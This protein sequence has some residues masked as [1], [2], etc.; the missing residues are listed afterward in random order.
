MEF[1]ERIRK[2]REALDMTQE[3]LAAA[4]GY[5][6]RWSINKIESGASDVSRGK[7]VEL[8][9]VLKTTPSYLMGWEDEDLEPD[10]PDPT[11]P[12]TT[13]DR[14][15]VYKKLPSMTDEQVTKMRKLF[16]LIDEE[17]NNE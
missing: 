2:L 17:L 10:H 12:A 9:R 13:P 16:E 3:E 7:I 11:I 1:G 4:V 5:T 15:W 8:A 14:D 6:G